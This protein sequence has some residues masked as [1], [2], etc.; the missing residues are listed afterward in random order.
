LRSLNT[1]GHLDGTK[2]SNELGWKPK[3][4]IEEGAKRYVQWRQA[5]QEK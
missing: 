4:S 3:I 1:E 2:A 5:Q